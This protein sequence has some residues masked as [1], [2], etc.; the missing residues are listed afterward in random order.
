MVVQVPVL[1]SMKYT[2]NEGNSF[3][4]HERQ[5]CSIYTIVRFVFIKTYRKIILK[6][7][8]NHT[9]PQKQ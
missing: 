1:H 4:C 6:L 7:N 9:L 2:I 5:T 8:T 3:G